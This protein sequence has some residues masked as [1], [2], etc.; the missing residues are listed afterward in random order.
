MVPEIPGNFKAKFKKKGAVND[1]DL[2]CPHFQDDYDAEPLFGVPCIGGVEG[3][4]HEGH[5]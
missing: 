1:N 3:G 4:G 5:W 2:F